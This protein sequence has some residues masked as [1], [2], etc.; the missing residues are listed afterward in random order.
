[1]ERDKVSPSGD[2]GSR[3]SSVW[4][5]PGLG[6]QR[7]LILPVSRRAWVLPPGAR[8]I[9]GL[10]FVPRPALHITLV[11][12]DAV[13]TVERARGRVHAETLL[14]QAFAHSDW[15]YRRS[16]RYLRLRRPQ[17]PAPDAGSIIERLELPGL[18]DFY[19]ALAAAG[20]TL[21]LPPAH[22]TLWTHARPQ[23]IGVADAAALDRLCVREVQ[24]H[25]LGL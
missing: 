5:W 14:R 25:E 2:R 21:P 23:G 7:A 24:A 11:G 22:V 16:H 4:S 20:I 1:M 9:D 19:R 17:P 8:V 15:R 6:A 13:A 12:R 10:A 3:A 18:E